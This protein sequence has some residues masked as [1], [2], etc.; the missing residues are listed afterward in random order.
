MPKAVQIMTFV[1]G[2]RP[3]HCGKDSNRECN[4]DRGQGTAAGPPLRKLP[5]HLG[6]G[7]ITL[8]IPRHGDDRK[9][10]EEAPKQYIIY[11]YTSTRV[12]P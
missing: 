9:G 3:K 4:E 12:L 7:I 1:V 8:G 6:K 2:T 10:R 11:R 5:K